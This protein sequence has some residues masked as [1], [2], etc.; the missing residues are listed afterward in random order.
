MKHLTFAVS[1]SVTPVVLAVTLA[2]CGGPEAGAPTPPAAGAPTSVSATTVP[3]TALPAAPT[4]TFAAQPV[5]PA[6][7]APEQ[8]AFAPNTSAASVEGNV[9]RGT[10]NS[11][12]LRATAG[13]QMDVAITS[14]EG[15]AVFTINGP[16][17]QPLAGA[18]PGQDASAWSGRLPL[19][20]D[21][22]ILVGAT[23]GNASFQ[24]TVSITGAATQPGSPIRQ[25]DWPAVL[26]ADPNLSA[27]QVEGQ[28]YV[29]VTAPDAQTGGHPL[30]KD[31]VYVDMDGDGVE[32]A[33]IPLNS[34]G[35]AGLVGFLV[36]RQATPVPQ[37]AAWQNGYKLN[38]STENS[39]LVV[40]N[41][42]YAGWEPNCCPSGLRY[43]SYKLQNGQLQVVASR[44]EP[45][46]GM[47]ITTVERFYQ[48]LSAGS[49]S[50]AYTLL[51][52][53]YRQAN[54]YQAWAAG[55]ATTSRIDAT[56]G[57]GS[58]PDRVQVELDATDLEPSGAEVT[59]RF[60]GSWRLVWSPE[61][62]GWLLTDPQIQPV[63]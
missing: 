53:D 32:E 41:A 15:N 60:S 20:G 35:T 4:P 54:P 16:D 50:E 14:L 3:A 47:Q 31:V 49:L 24:L 19:D 26:S 21:Y 34:G 7:P 46:P 39:Q 59:R 10:Q 63:P 23:R 9:L 52:A 44:D 43:T 17:G 25:T 36:Y 8:I 27:E 12:L 18:E 33:A 11:Y 55:Y 58:G 45:N 2:A 13:Q 22:T 56:V 61:L 62:P 30:T 40:G 42:L 51:A 28:L 1:R 37:L 6:S 38:L 48:L 57:Q 29:N 5:D